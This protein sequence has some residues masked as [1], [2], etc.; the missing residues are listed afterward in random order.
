[1]QIY[2]EKEPICFVSI[3]HKQVHFLWIFVSGD[4]DS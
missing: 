2:E 4:V 1:M 3:R